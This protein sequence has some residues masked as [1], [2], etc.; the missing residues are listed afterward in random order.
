[1][2]HGK[3]VAYLTF[4]VLRRQGRHDIERIRKLT[5]LA[6]LHDVGA[7]K[8][9]EIDRM[10]QFETEN[11]WGHSIYGY[12]FVKYF[13]PIKELAP[14]ILFHHASCSE[15]TYLDPSLCEYA[16]IIHIADRFDILSQTQERDADLFRQYFDQRRGE[17]F[18][19]S[20]VDLFFYEGWE[21]L[22]DGMEDD[23]AFNDILYGGDFSE[24]DLE[25]FIKMIV[26]SID[27]R[28][29]QT[30][31][32]TFTSTCVCRVISD[33]I[34]IDP[35]EMAHLY[36]SMMLHDLGKIGIPSEILEKAGR[37]SEAEMSV[38]KNH[39]NLTREILSEY[40][41]ECCVELAARHHEKLNG[42]GYP[43]GLAAKNLTMGQ[44]LVGVADI[45]SALCG[46]RTYKE[47]FPKEKVAS[48]LL[49]MSG[50]GLIDADIV[51][52]VLQNYENLMEEV[53]KT[54][55]PIIETYKRMQTENLALLKTVAHFGDGLGKGEITL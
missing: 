54:T 34:S 55:R 53:E 35:K 29:P 20:I 46:V 10:V 27:F 6:L 7:Y 36:T 1:M 19:P 44:R 11:V 18:A 32:H 9:E 48:I 41:D 4:K 51:S 42:A 43:D 12:L 21:A 30:V 31:T 3:R 15:I 2:N 16:Q 45:F 23:K 50:Q 17:L 47:A 25:A 52:A 22:F 26:L 33:F 13:S 28:S 40:A 14:V 37:L 24:E 39:V 49:D 5:I 8:T 38:M